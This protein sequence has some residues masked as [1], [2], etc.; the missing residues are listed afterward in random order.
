MFTIRSSFS[1]HQTRRWLILQLLAVLS[2]SDGKVAWAEEHPVVVED[3]EDGTSKT[4]RVDTPSPSGPAGV[5]SPDPKST[6]VVPRQTIVIPVNFSS[7]PTVTCSQASLSSTVFGAANSV[8]TWY[9]ETSFGKARFAGLTIPPVTISAQS[10]SCDGSAPD[11]WANEADAAAQLAGY[12]VSQY[13]HRVYIIPDSINCPWIGRAFMPGTRAWV[14]WCDFLPTYTH[15]LGHNLGMHHARQGGDEY[16]D[17]SDTMG[18]SLHNL[19]AP[20]MVQMNYTPA[21]KVQAVNVGGTFNIAPLLTVPS[22]TSLP[23]ILT[24]RVPGS[25]SLRYFIS[26]RATTGLSAGLPAPYANRIN[27]HRH[28]G[29]RTRTDFVVSLGD[30]ETWVQ[31]PITITN[32][33]SSGKGAVVN[34]AISCSRETPLVEVTPFFQVGSP[35]TALDYSVKLTNQD[36]GSCPAASFNLGFQTQSSQITGQF[37]SSAILLAP[38]NSSEAVLRVRSLANA[39]TGSNFFDVAADDPTIPGHTGYGSGDYEVSP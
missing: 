2:A 27:I 23:Q 11:V 39:Q 12:N 22:Q 32:V 10:Q 24:I 36:L 38:G 7:G 14:R 28:D 20:H 37:L 1:R 29:Y 21:A 3:N 15:E 35:G 6:R 31:G 13:A 9:K 33:R 17:S 18:I 8:D 16:G 19:N 34:A 25:A 30:G 5:D 4:L 26:F